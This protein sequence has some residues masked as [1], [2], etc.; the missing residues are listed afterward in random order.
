MLV[1]MRMNEQFDYTMV[2]VMN[3]YVIFR[4]DEARVSH[5]NIIH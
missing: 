5:D 4:M 3:N 2:E 1:S